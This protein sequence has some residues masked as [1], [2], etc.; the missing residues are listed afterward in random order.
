VTN[1]VERAAGCY[2]GFYTR[3]QEGTKMAV[4][5]LRNGLGQTSWSRR[6]ESTLWGCRVPPLPTLDPTFRGRVP[7]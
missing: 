5:N 6:E 2:S 3:L 7:S 1:A 4:S